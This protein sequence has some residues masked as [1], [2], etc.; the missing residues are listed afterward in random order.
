ME[1]LVRAIN[2][3]GIPNQA[4]YP[5]IHELDLF[6]SGEYRK[7]LCGAQANESHS[8]LHAKYPHTARGAFETI[9]IPQP[10]LLG[11]E[12]DI[13]EIAAAWSKVQR[14]AKELV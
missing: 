3:E 7:R 10:A 12:E 13:H 11:D 1:Q 14:L 8:F 6:K 5:P 2:A 9:W 4:S